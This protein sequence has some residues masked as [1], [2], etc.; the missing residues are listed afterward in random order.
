[1]KNLSSPQRNWTHKSVR[2]LIRE[3]GGGD[4]VEVIRAKTREIVA[5]AKLHNWSGPP[6]NPLELASLRGIQFRQ[7]K[8]LF[9]AEAQL[10]PMDGNQ[11]LLEFNPD[12]SPG[13]QN[14]S[15]SH[16]LVHTLFD[17][18]F[19][20]VH[21]RRN[22]RDSFDPEREI[23][24]LCQIGAAEF[25]MPADDF[26]A[27]M[28]TRLLSLK[29]VP[30]LSERYGASREAAARRML[31]LSANACALVFFSKRLKPTEIDAEKKGSKHAEPRM[32]ILYSSPTADFPLF[33]PEHKSVPAD[34]SVNRAT[35]V[36]EVF[37]GYEDWGIRGF[38][39][40]F[41]EA[42]ALP[43]PQG[44]DASTPSVVAFVHGLTAER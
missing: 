21:Q 32:R 16:E 8:G 23:E 18:C 15:I 41:V 6:Y 30:F 3:A 33:L 40:R 24:Y 22:D 31:S 20:M 36:D 44:V 14:Y 4:P 43:L 29:S 42:M 9:T 37:S 11:L 7:S 2:A 38:G 28:N 5:W 17:D 13:R 39:R 35:E 10:T 25:L 12:R 26:S 1:M 19:E 34:S 27:D